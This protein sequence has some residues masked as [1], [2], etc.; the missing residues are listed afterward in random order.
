MV[1]CKDCKYRQNDDNICHRFPPSPF[2]HPVQNPLSGEVQ[3]HAINLAVVVAD[4]YWC[5]E[6]KEKLMVEG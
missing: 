3:M 2:P 5:G 4:D 1:K 6:Y